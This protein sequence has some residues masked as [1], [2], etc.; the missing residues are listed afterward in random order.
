MKCRVP[1]PSVDPD[2]P[3]HLYHLIRFCTVHVMVRNN[4]RNQKANTVDPDQI[5]QMCQ[6]IWTTL[7]AHAIKAYIW[8]KGL[9][10]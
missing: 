7:F 10:S 2:Q 4:L 8:R 5:A 3:A 1:K 9:Y 6:L